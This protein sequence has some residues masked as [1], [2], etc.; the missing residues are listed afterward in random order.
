M[1]YRWTN[2]VAHETVNI[3]QCSCDGLFIQNGV[4]QPNIIQDNLHAL[5][6]KEIWIHVPKIFE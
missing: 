1:A 4:S 6:K 5:N 2:H 3:V